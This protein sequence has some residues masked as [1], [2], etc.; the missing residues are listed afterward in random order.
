ME[1]NKKNSSGSALKIGNYIYYVSGD[2]DDYGDSFP[3]E[4]IQLFNDD[5]ISTEIIG[6][7]EFWSYQPVLLEATPDFCV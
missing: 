5:V 7:H 1:N 4:R 2:G 3:V 6:G